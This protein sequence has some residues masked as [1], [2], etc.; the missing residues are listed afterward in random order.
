MDVENLEISGNFKVMEM[1]K[2]L[3]GHEHLYRG[4]WF[5]KSLTNDYHVSSFVIWLSSKKQNQ[6][7]ML[8]WCLLI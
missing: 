3:K 8:E 1:N 5:L 7:I 4:W 2:D 6:D